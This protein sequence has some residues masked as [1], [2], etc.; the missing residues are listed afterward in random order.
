MSQF[1]SCQQVELSSSSPQ[2]AADRPAAPWSHLKW[3]GQIITS[4]MDHLLHF[5][6]TESD[7]LGHFKVKESN[8]IILT[9]NTVPFKNS[10]FLATNAVPKL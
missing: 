8:E 5:L 9:G 4:F 7:T 2:V 3:F 10:T 1:A 6:Y